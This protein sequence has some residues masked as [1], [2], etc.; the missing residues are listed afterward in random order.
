MIDGRRNDKLAQLISFPTFGRGTWLLKISVT[1]HRTIMALCAN[2]HDPENT[3][4]RFFRN[5]EDINS[6]IDFLILQKYYSPDPE[7]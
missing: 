3:F 4:L 1:N 6:F 5:K 2:A 7:T